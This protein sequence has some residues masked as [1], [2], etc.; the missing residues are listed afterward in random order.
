MEE[1]TKIK[2][3]PTETVSSTWRRKKA[4]YIPD[5]RKTLCDWLIDIW[6]ALH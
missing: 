3:P 2:A 5:I 4:E 1:E 6:L